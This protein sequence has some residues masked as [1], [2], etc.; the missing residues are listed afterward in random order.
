MSRAE[1][2][3]RTS[4]VTLHM[5]SSL[6]GIIAKKDNSV[7]WLDDTGSVYEAGV[8][9]SEEEAATFVKAIDCYVLGSRTY[10]HALELGW[11]YGDTPAVVVT[12]RERPPARQSVEFYSG[13]IETSGSW[14]GP[15]CAGV[16]SSSAWWTKSS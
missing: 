7:S 6:D 8:S 4:T 1:V 11:P 2:N 10:E 12:G 16:F 5:V 14:A 13:D 3:A 15:C 9:I